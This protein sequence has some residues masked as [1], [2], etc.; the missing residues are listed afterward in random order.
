MLKYS[1]LI[2]V[3]L[4]LMII[5]FSV[6]AN[7]DIDNPKLFTEDKS[8]EDKAK[9]N[10]D[11]KKDDEVKAKKVS[12]IVTEYI[13]GL[14]KAYLE[15]P[16]DVKLIRKL[17]FAYLSK[18]DVVGAFKYFKKLKEKKYKDIDELMDFY[19]NHKLGI[20]NDKGK[21][22]SKEKFD[23]LIKKYKKNK[24]ENKFE[25][26]KIMFVKNKLPVIYG[27]YE[28]LE[29]NTFSANQTVA[30]YIELA[31]YKIFEEGEEKFNVRCTG[32]WKVL[33]D[34]G[35]RMASQENIYKYNDNSKSKLNDICMI[36]YFDVPENLPKGKSYFLQI[37]MQD[38][39]DKE[40]TS[41]KKQ[42]VFKIK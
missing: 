30:I 18:N 40:Q 37:K 7:D 10:P 14:E 31:N 12:E 41:D 42:L 21:L 35:A 26:Q 33:S 39:N 22:K 28:K 27:Q 25:I 19:L 34:L 36:L 17:Y 9:S 32:G 24:S 4:N 8:K 2:L 1:L 5:N 11:V 38:E 29:S 15:K 20:L 16:E 3:L 6:C 23:K 13:D